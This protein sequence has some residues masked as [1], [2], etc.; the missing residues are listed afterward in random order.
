MLCFK[1]IKVINGKKIAVLCCWGFGQPM[2]STEFEES[3]FFTGKSLLIY[4]NGR[5]WLSNL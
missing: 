3:F 4:K 2:S 1:K 5:L